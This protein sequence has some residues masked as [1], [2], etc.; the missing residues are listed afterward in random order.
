MIMMISLWTHPAWAS[1]EANRADVAQFD[2]LPG[3]GLKRAA[4]L[5]DERRARGP[6]LDWMDLTDRVQGLGAR[7]AARLS[8]AGL[9]V[10]GRA[11]D[12]PPPTT[13]PHSSRRSQLA[14]PNSTRTRSQRKRNAV[15]CS[16]ETTDPGKP[17]MGPNIRF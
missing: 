12:G 9:T 3:I 11:Y 5:V 15:P 10:N 17:A 4:A 6:F 16:C 2:A 7:S 13:P 14:T 1:V 8:A